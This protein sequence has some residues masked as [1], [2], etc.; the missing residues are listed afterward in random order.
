MTRNKKVFRK[1]A[2][3][4]L[5]V[6]IPAVLI[7]S[8]L[9][10]VYLVILGGLGGLKVSTKKERMD[11]NSGYKNDLALLDSYYSFLESPINYNSEKILVKDLVA[12]TLEDDKEKF[13]EFKGLADDFLEKNVIEE[14]KTIMIL[15]K[16]EMRNVW[17]K[18]YGFNEEIKQDSNNQYS[19]YAVHRVANSRYGPSSLC[20]PKN[21][22]NS[23]FYYIIPQNKKI[24]MC[25]EYA[26]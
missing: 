1:K 25:V 12:G 8:F 20:D 6:L 22:E 21:P 16:Y 17:I 18:V 13:K 5:L 15:S 3:A 26:K 4:S 10:F 7:L 24:V 14:K 23:V 19:S 9:L 2:F 11:F